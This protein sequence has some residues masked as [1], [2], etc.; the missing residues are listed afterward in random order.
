MAAQ[1]SIIA[2][3]ITDAPLLPIQMQRIAR[4]VGLGV[5]RTGTPGENG[6]GDIFLALSTGNDVADKG[7]D[8]EASV[9]YIPNHDLDALFMAT[10]EAT[11]EAIINALVAAQTMTGQNGHMAHA[12]DHDELLETMKKYGR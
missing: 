11:E 5:G 7:N 4:R 6:S 9:R 8:V 12:I 3:A 10:V 2:I 1:G